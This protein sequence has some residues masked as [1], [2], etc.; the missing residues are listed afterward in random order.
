[1]SDDQGATSSNIKA[2]RYT[3][4]SSPFRNDSNIDTSNK[5]RNKSEIVLASQTLHR[6]RNKTVNEYSNKYIDD[7][8]LIVVDPS[9]KITDK[10]SNYCRLLWI[11][12]SR[13]K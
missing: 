3:S 11:F 7:F 4:V 2:T 9:T 12:F 5:S 10:K 6:K 1:M 13:S 8:K